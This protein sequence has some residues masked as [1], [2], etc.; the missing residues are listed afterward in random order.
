[1]IRYLHRCPLAQ[2]LFPCQEVV[3]EDHVKFSL[4]LVATEESQQHVVNGSD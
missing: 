2:R 1:M 4:V 3:C